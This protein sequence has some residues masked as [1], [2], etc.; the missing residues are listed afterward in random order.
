MIFFPIIK[1]W[2]TDSFVGSGYG[3]NNS[4]G[5]INTLIPLNQISK[6]TD[7]KLFSLMSQIKYSFIKP[8]SRL[9]ITGTSKGIIN[10]TS[11]K[12]KNIILFPGN[13]DYIL[14]QNN[15]EVWP[16][17][18][19]YID[20]SKKATVNNTVDGHFNTIKELLKNVGYKEEDKLNT[21]SYDF[22]NIDFEEVSNQFNQFLKE[23]TIIIAY[24][25]GTVMAN[26]SIQIN[27]NNNN[28]NLNNYISKLI[29][30][31]P[32]IGGI[33]MTLRDYFSGNGII[34]PAVIENYDSILLSMPNQLVYDYR[35]VAIYNSLSY[36]PKDISKLLEKNNNPIDKYN[37]LQQLQKLSI[38]PPGVNCIIVASEQF[39]TPI[40]YN[41]RNNLRQSP[42]RYL[43]KNNNQFPNSDIKNNGTFEGIQDFGDK[44]VPISSI[45]KL[46]NMWNSSKLDNNLNKKCTLEL[47]KDKHHFSIL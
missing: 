29:L 27:N 3:L 5:K 19:H 37:D 38:K 36:Y 25:F 24:D 35:P 10:R 47:I 32:T 2:T 44:V 41:F 20:N 45:Y 1:S 43:A 23:D 31:C 9:E 26:I 11:N 46:K 21:I 13:T 16:K 15:R 39:N 40:C 8:P 6:A 33:P 12:L 34:E 18:T 42:E 22:R 17:D 4:F 30:I 28:N 14:K 7:F